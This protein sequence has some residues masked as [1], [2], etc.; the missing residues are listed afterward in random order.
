MMAALALVGSFVLGSGTAAVSFLK[1]AKLFRDHV[2]HCGCNLHWQ[3]KLSEIISPCEHRGA[4]G[5]GKFH[6]DREKA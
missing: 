1:M 4:R 6:W 3:R 5:P 2:R